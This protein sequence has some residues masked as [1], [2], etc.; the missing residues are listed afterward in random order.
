MG[1]LKIDDGNAAGSS[2]ENANA[3]K[4]ESSQTIQHNY[5]NKNESYRILYPLVSA[6]FVEQ[7][8]EQTAIATF[9]LTCVEENVRT[10]L[11]R[12]GE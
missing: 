12:T 3:F 1:N 11:Q 10:T 7:T 8:S 5:I 9:C 6:L 2:A 4:T